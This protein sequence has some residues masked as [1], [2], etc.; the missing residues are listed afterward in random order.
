MTISRSILMIVLAFA[1]SAKGQTVPAGGPVQPTQSYGAI[2]IKGGGIKSG[3]KL[4]LGRKRFYL[5]SG[6]AKDNAALIERIKNAQ[7]MSRDCYYSGINASACLIDWL[8]QENCETPFC[9]KIEKADLANVREF[10]AAY[11]KGLPLYGRKPNIALDWVANN[12]PAN[13]ASG[14]YLQQRTLI[15]QILKGVRPVESA[16][17]TAGAAQAQF[18]NIPVGAAPSP[19]VIS[20]VLPVE[21]GG[22]SYVWTCDTTVAAK[23]LTIILNTDPTKQKG[24]C[25]VQVR[26]VKVCATSACEKK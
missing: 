4:A 3:G 8:R 9:R 16:M 14:Y 25:T 26:D 23:K 7:I 10:Q 21:I 2:D 11:T 24:G 5:F 15:E 17:T 12:L 19:V 20:N 13:I 18:V 1:A 22:K 6:N